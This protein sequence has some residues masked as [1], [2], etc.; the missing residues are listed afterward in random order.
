MDIQK[1]VQNIFD[2]AV[3]SDLNQAD[4]KFLRNIQSSFEL[5][6]RQ[7]V[8]LEDIEQRVGIEYEEDEE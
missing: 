8:W 1:R 7:L 6:T 2:E 4:R 5:S 3:G